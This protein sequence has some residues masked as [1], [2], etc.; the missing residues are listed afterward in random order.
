M[1]TGVRFCVKFAF[2]LVSLFVIAWKAAVLLGA[3]DKIIVVD[4]FMGFYIPKSAMIMRRC[5]VGLLKFGHLGF[6]VH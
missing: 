4:L 5:S 6:F 1:K 2:L 3:G